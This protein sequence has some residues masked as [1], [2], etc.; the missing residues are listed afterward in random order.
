M[1]SDE[2]AMFQAAMF[3][4]LSLDPFALFDDPEVGFGG[5]HGI[6]APMVALVIAVLNERTPRSSA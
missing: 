4:G 3:D 6:Q 1:L 5:R 2:L